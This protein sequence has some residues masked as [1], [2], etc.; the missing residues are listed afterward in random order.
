MLAQRKFLSAMGI[1]TK[2]NNVYPC[3]KEKNVQGA[4]KIIW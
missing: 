4:L 1:Q 3:L 2:Q